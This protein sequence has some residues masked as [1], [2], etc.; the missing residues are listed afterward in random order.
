MLRWRLTQTVIA[1]ASAEDDQSAMMWLRWTLA[2]VRVDQ[3]MHVAWKVLLPL[4]F[5]NLGVTGLLVLVLSPM[6]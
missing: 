6:G 3:L 1:V 4:A 5:V 2:R